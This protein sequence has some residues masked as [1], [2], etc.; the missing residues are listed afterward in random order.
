LGFGGGFG[1]GFAVF[2]EASASISRSSAF[3]FGGL[4]VGFLWVMYN[5][6]GCGREN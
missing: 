3:V 1:S 4:R 6:W 5:M 2:R